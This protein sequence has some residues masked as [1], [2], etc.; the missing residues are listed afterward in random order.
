MVECSLR[1]DTL[2]VSARQRAGYFIQMLA[3]RLFL[4]EDVFLTV[5]GHMIFQIRISFV[6]DYT[7]IFWK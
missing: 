6:E 2:P 4:K 1:A 5:S 3:R 7:T